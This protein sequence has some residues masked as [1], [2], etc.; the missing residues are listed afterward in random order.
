MNSQR[1]LSGLC[2]LLVSASTLSAA[3]RFTIEAKLKPG[4]APTSYVCAVQVLE[5]P[6]GATVIERELTVLP[7][8]PAIARS[9]KQ[10]GKGGEVD[11][12]IECSLSADGGTA[13]IR[14][15]NTETR[16]GEPPL[17]AT[18]ERRL[19]VE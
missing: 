2:A 7:G 15:T 5:H 10:D 14:F 12:K 11:R 1:F 13:V 3:E 17:T 19:K 8:T 9:G 4:T 16:K 6:G 18:L